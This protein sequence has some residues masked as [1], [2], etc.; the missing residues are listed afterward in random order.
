MEHG[1]NITKQLS[2]WHEI[3]EHSHHP[4]KA[5]ALLKDFAVCPLGHEMRFRHQI[6]LIN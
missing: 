5:A 1:F 6:M 4:I 2:T 3:A